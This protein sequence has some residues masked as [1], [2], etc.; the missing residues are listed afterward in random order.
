M[1]LSLSWGAAP[2][3]LGVQ[4]PRSTHSP[5]G[6]APH[7]PHTGRGDGRMAKHMVRVR[8]P[9]WLSCWTCLS[10][11]SFYFCKMEPLGG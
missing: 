7:H 1:T 2:L 11:F 3:F 10:S 6:L 9:L 8:A 4:S 5:F